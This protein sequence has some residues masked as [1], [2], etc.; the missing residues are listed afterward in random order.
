MAAPRNGDPMPRPS[1]RVHALRV[2]KL[3]SLWEHAV[4]E[5]DLHKHRALVLLAVFM[6]MT[7]TA[8]AW[9]GTGRIDAGT[10]GVFAGLMGVGV[11]Y[12]LLS[13]RTLPR[14]L[15]EAVKIRLQGIDTLIAEEER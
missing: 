12:S 1:D 14:R 7:L 10:G 13:L 3:R 11:G 15:R 9:V 2:E 6:T 4:A 5:V 8:L